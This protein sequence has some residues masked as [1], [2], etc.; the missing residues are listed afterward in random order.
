MRTPGDGKAVPAYCELRNGN[1]LQATIAHDSL[2]GTSLVLASPECLFQRGERVFA[3]YMLPVIFITCCCQAPLSF[4][5]CQ[6]KLQHSDCLLPFPLPPLSICSILSLYSMPYGSGVGSSIN[7]S[8][9]E[10]ASGGVE[11]SPKVQLLV[12]TRQENGCRAP[13]IISHSK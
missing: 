4:L 1:R 3:L 6:H 7:C 2:E 12:V 5:R 8:C 11:C 10:V 13:C 9:R